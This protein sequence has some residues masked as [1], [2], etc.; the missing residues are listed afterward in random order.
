MDFQKM[1]FSLKEELNKKNSWGKNELKGLMENIEMQ[2]NN[3]RLVIGLD[4][5]K[6]NQS[7][8]EILDKLFKKNGRKNE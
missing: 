5:E 2:A 4:S 7:A 1:W 6:N 3:S 8:A